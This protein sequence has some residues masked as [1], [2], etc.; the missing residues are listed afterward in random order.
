MSTAADKLAFVLE[1]IHGPLWKGK[2][3]TLNER[4][5]RIFGRMSEEELEARRTTHFRWM[6]T[7][8]KRRSAALEELCTALRRKFGITINPTWIVD[9]DLSL[10]EF[11]AKL[12]FTEL[13]L[14]F[15]MLDLMLNRA[16]HEPDLLS[17]MGAHVRMRKGIWLLERWTDEARTLRRST[18]IFVVTEEMLKYRL[19]AQPRA[20]HFAYLFTPFGGV[21][22]DT[23]SRPGV[24]KYVGRGAYVDGSLE[25]HF[26]SVG[27]TPPDKADMRIMASD[28]THSHYDG[29]YVSK[30]ID[31]RGRP[32]VRWI[33]LTY[34]DENVSVES[35][36]WHCAQFVRSADDLAS[37][38]QTTAPAAQRRGGATGLA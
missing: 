21:N 28:E 13:Q 26:S 22:Q 36:D 11:A 5:R 20:C 10:I 38:G 32:G 8:A 16:K 33:N 7:G 2:S 24:T 19:E 6:K 12:G 23:T 1:A 29:G 4:L 34:L 31:K 37:N 9:T 30:N 35:I 18:C 15:A 17:P 3:H 25:F 14:D 27:R